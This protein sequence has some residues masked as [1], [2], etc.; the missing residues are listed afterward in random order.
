MS[1]FTLKLEDFFSSEDFEKFNSQWNNFPD[2]DK[3]T[4]PSE[5]HM[6]NPVIGKVMQLEDKSVFRTKVFQGRNKLRKINP[7][8]NAP[9]YLM[10]FWHL[11]HYWLT[12]EQ[13]YHAC[14]EKIRPNNHKCFVRDLPG[15]VKIEKPIFWPSKVQGHVS[16]IGLHKI[17]KGSWERGKALESFTI[18][19]YDDKQNKSYGYLSGACFMQFRSYVRA[20]QDLKEMKDGSFERMLRLVEN[21]ESNH[22]YLAIPRNDLLISGE[23]LKENLRKGILPTEEVVDNFFSLY[24]LDKLRETELQSI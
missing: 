8:Y 22:Q 18:H 24:N 4:L 14:M 5:V 2:K 13:F 10:P 20:Y 1:E 23:E 7:Y 15:E 3:L 16:V 6:G 12:G 9:F 11:V 19:F 21:Q 17:L